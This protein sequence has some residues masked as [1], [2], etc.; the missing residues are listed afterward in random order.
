[1]VD[2]KLAIP[3]SFYCTLNTHYRIV[4]YRTLCLKRANFGKW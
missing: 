1:V 3:V 4:S 2:Y